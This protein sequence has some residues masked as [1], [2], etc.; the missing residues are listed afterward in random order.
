MNRQIIPIITPPQTLPHIRQLFL[1][2]KNILLQILL[3]EII[4][5]R[6]PFC[7]ILDLELELLFP[8]FLELHL[9]HKKLLAGN[10]FILIHEIP[11][12][13]SFD[14]DLLEILNSPIPLSLI[15]AQLT[16]LTFL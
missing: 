5:G 10:K 13:F 1:Q 16:N 12:I 3:G 4:I 8:I 14:T 2:T 6:Q 9:G 7:L 15:P 11:Q